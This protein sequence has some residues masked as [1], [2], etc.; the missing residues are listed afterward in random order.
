MNKLMIM[1]VMV[2]LLMGV[3]SA[4]RSLVNVVNFS[5]PSNVIAGSSFDASFSFDYPNVDKNYNNAPLVA[6]VNI[7]SLDSNYPVWKNDFQLNMIAEQYLLLGFYN[8][9]TIP[10]PCYETAPIQFKVK[11]K[12]DVQYTINEIPNGTFYCYNPNY[13]MLQLDSHD[14]VTLEITSDPALYPGKYNI[15][16]DLLEMEPDESDPV[17]ELIAPVGDDIFSETNE[18]IPIKLNITD[19]YAIDDSSVRYKI[20]EVGLPADGEGLNIPYYDS[21]WI[22]D[23]S[24]NESSKFYEA[25]FNMAEHGLNKSGSYWIY[26]EAKDVLGNEG[27]L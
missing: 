27:K 16:I 12:S 24:Y 3:V 7:E 14:E 25:E 23:I 21:D 18:V 20:I 6:R 19:M 15:S 22:Y 2:F 13:Y 4:D 1:F 17:I 5:I 8:Y 9:N 10:M 26:A 11:D